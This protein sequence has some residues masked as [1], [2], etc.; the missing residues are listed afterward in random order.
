MRSAKDLKDIISGARDKTKLNGIL[1]V[2]E[3][4]NFST[5]EDDFDEKKGGEDVAGL[6]REIVEL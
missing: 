5:A 2:N 3:D 4:T 1:G 6:K